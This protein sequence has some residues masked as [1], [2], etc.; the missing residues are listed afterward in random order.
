MRHHALVLALTVV[1][2]GLTV[3]VASAATPAPAQAPAASS[4]AAVGT[5]EPARTGPGAASAQ[6]SAR[7]QAV[8]TVGGCQVFPADNP[9]NTRIDDRPVLNRSAKIISR[10]AA[11]HPVHLDL[12]STEEY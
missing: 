10:Q 5:G 6:T 9:W 3:A 4:R 8:H 2:P 7:A 11:G 1:A 12:G